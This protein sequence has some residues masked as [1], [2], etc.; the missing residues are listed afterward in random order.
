MRFRILF[1]SFLILWI[2]SLSVVIGTGEGE[3]GN[4]LM[5]RFSMLIGYSSEVSA[6]STGVLVVPGTVITL[7]AEDASS[8]VSEVMRIQA[9]QLEDLAQRLTT[10]LRL[11]RV[12]VRYWDTIQVP[13][14]QTVDLAPPVPESKIAIAVELLGYTPDLAT[15]QVRFRDGEQMLVDTSVSIEREGRA[16]VGGMDGEFTPYFFLLIEPLEEDPLAFGN[17]PSITA[18]KLLSGIQPNYPEECRKQKIE[19]FV[20]IE[21]LIGTDGQVRQ[22][23]AKSSPHPLLADA[24]IVAA[25]QW[26]FTPAQRDGE[27]VTVRYSLVIRFALK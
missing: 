7:A 19:G 10:T 15:Y 4:H 26:K 13:L 3:P 8:A 9:Q 21:A 2:F 25:R 24:A 5:T 23:D 11:A 1:S 22:V 14:K 6:E 20:V 27:A 17:N 18:P 16:V 12:E